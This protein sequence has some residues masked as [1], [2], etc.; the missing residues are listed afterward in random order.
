MTIVLKYDTVELLV[1]KACWVDHDYYIDECFVSI[2][3][4][5]GKCVY[6]EDEPGRAI[7]IEGRRLN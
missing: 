6:C 2:F 1:C 5:P 3:N 7:L 4:G